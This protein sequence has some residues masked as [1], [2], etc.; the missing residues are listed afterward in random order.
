MTDPRTVVT[1]YVEAVAA[2]DLPTI[3]ASFAPDVVWTYPGDLP[4][5]G[6]WKGRDRVVD[7]FLGA[8][9]GNLFA[10][11]TPVAI[12]LVNVIADGEQVF[13]EWTAQATARDGGAYSNKCAGVFTVRGGLIVAVREYL[14]TDHA[15]RVLFPD[16][17]ML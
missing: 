11:G 9:A 1:R 4:L 10:P 2:G 8:A 13:A 6:D 12:G 16:D 15:R 3:R 14:D 7:E 5:S 17:P